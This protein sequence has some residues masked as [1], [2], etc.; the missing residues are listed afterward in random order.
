VLSN[1]KSPHTWQLLFSLSYQR[2]KPY[3]NRHHKATHIGLIAHLL[4]QAGKHTLSISECY[5]NH[6]ITS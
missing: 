6:L 2:R 1:K 3:G 4:T 5:S